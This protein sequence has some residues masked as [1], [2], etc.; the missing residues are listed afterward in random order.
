MQTP[1]TAIDML[2]P[3]QVCDELHLDEASL[4]DLVNRGHLAAYDLGGHIRFRA[5]DVVATLAL[6]AVA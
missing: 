5:T 1:S 3:T 2:T 6:L 4:L